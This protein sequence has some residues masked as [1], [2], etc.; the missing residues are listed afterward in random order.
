LDLSDPRHVRLL[1]GSLP[2]ARLRVFL[3]GQGASGA[4][5]FGD[6]RRLSATLVEHPSGETCLEAEP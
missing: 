2:P 1:L 5:L 4:A 3:R 6:G